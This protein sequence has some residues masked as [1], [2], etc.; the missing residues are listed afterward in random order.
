MRPRILAV[1]V[2]W[3]EKWANRPRFIVLV[4]E[5]PKLE[6]YR[7]EEN[8]HVYF[9]S[10]GACVQYFTYTQPDKGFGGSKITVTMQDETK[11]E[12]IGPWSGNSATVNKLG[13]LQCVEAVLFDNLDEFVEGNGGLAGAVA[14]PDLA[15]FMQTEPLP[16]GLAR[17]RWGGADW[18]EPTPLKESYGDFE[19]IEVIV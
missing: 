8:D 18:Y 6:D 12:L 14:I 16:F 11:R 3:M 2:D 5:I 19:E 15:L 10:C 13:G 4:D 9:A 1:R 17:V 7:F